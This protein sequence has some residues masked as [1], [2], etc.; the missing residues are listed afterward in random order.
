MVEDGGVKWD[1]KSLDEL[2][3]PNMSQLA[4][5]WLSLHGLAGSGQAEGHES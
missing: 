3:T 2:H 1:V 5:R 4:H